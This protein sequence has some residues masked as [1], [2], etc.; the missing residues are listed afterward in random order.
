MDAD[1]RLRVLLIRL[2]SAPEARSARNFPDFGAAYGAAAIACVAIA[3]H[4]LSGVIALIG[5][6]TGALN[7]SLPFRERRKADVALCT[8]ILGAVITPT[9]YLLCRWGIV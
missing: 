1:H 7:R 6:L 5:S 9:W 4:V 8:T 2:P 3:T